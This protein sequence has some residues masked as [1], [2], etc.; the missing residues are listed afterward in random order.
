MSEN[1]LSELNL[2]FSHS[3]SRASKDNKTK[4]THTHSPDRIITTKSEKRNDSVYLHFVGGKIVSNRG[5]DGQ[6][7]TYRNIGVRERESWQLCYELHL[8]TLILDDS[9]KR[10]QC[11]FLSA[12]HDC[13]CHTLGESEVK[14]H[15][16]NTGTFIGR[17]KSKPR[18]G[19]KHEEIIASVL[20]F[21]RWDWSAEWS[22]DTNLDYAMTMSFLEFIQ[23][24]S[25][26]WQID[27]KMLAK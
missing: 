11:H 18:K 1:H 23:S 26:F 17:K 6:Q 13:E 4:G 25:N 19:K 20:T 27:R 3:N 21:M 14:A 5:W 15:T 8:F 12:P 9:N 7:N 22:K 10:I 2:K 16:K 24:N